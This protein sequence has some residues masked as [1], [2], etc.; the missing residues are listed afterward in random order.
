METQAHDSLNQYNDDHINSS[1]FLVDTEKYI[2]KVF[3]RVYCMTK[4]N[5]CLEG[6]K[7]ILLEFIP[8]SINWCK[9]FSPAK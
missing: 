2:L 9:L 4:F 6:T 5:K 3:D 8:C 7:I 1:E